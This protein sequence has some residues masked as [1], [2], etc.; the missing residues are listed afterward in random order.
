MSAWGIFSKRMQGLIHSTHPRQTTVCAGQGVGMEKMG[1]DDQ[2]IR[3][4][5][6]CFCLE[7]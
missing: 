3:P 6:K 5:K 4:V 7:L 2:F 1:K